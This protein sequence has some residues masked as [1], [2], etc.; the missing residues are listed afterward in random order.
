MYFRSD[1]DIYV[2]ALVFNV[3]FHTAYL[4]KTITKQ[5]AASDIEIPPL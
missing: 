5:L 2:H 1:E 3:R 4:K